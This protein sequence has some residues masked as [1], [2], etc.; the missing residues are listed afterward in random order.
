MRVK[1]WYQ[2]DGRVARV[3]GGWRGLGLPMAQA[4]DAMGCRP[5]R[6]ARQVAALAAAQRQ[7]VLDGGSSVG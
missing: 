1:D 3:A 4:P 7:L 5:A 6:T 2:L